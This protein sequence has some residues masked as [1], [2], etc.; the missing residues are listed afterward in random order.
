[1]N[2]YLTDMLGAD[3]AVLKH[4]D[5]TL[6]GL[7]GE[8]IDERKNILVLSTERGKKIVPKTRGIIEVEGKQVS[9]ERI[10]ARPE[11]KMK[12]SRR[13]RR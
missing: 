1:M 10:R 7:R 3:V 6:I 12:K 8:C 2:P 11:E 13:W 4:T 9:L 5:R